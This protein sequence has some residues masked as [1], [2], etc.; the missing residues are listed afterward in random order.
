MS[1]NINDFSLQSQKDMSTPTLITERLILQKFTTDDF[2]ALYKIYSDEEINKFLP[3]FPWKTLEEARAFFKSN[4]KVSMIKGAI[5]TGSIASLLRLPSCTAS[6]W[7]CSN[8]CGRDRM[9][10]ELSKRGIYT[11]VKTVGEKS[12]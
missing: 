8:Q 6:F 11:A 10:T 7:Y 5:C 4:L 12:L 3:W 9:H 2:K 1:Y